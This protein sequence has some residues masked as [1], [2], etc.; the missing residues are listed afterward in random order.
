MSFR[1]QGWCPGALRPMESGDGLVVRIRPRLAR[2]SAVQAQGL[3][4]AALAHG[5]GQIEIT[6]RGNI[7][8]RGVTTSRHAPLLARLDA[9]GLIDA[10]EA[11][12]R[13]RNVTVTP[14]WQA[15]DGTQ[16]LAGALYGALRD[17]PDLP[18]KFGFALDTGPRPVLSGTS[19]DIRIERATTGGLLIRADGAAGGGAVS[20]GEAVPRAMAM[21]K[22]FLA[23]GGVEAGR[24]RMAR[25]LAHATLPFTTDTAPAVSAAGTGPGLVPL[26]ALVA[27]EFGLIR[28]ELFGELAS[29]PLRITP[30]RM[31]LIEGAAE[32]PRQSG[33]IT[34]PADPRLRVM[35]CTGQPGCPQ[36]LQK[37]RPLARRL[38][39]LVPEGKRLHV[40]GC[41]KGCACP[42]VADVTLSGTAR[43][44]GLIVRGRAGDMPQALLSPD[45]ITVETLSK[46]F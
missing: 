25:H 7:Q 42:G 11:E 27:L 16:D 44:F 17:G 18:G 26:G 45:E 40:S 2:L 19:A 28:G 43:G 13:H 23:S 34:D 46:V 20:E 8:L 32:M 21:A 29:A 24:G 38:A 9:L 5:N 33:L 41:A 31:L 22:W 6:S 35:A 30:W 15:G 1:V 3:A 39:A 37:T 12:E 36:A 4:E 10:S 14:F